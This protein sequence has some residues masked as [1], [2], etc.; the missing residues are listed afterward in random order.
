MTG[1]TAEVDR[2]LAGPARLPDEA[3]SVLLLAR[4]I[5]TGSADERARRTA[6]SIAGAGTPFE[7][8]YFLGR[9]ADLGRAS[10]VVAFL[11]GP[12]GASLEPYDR[13][14]LKL[15]AYSMLEW[16]VLE[17]KEI[18][19]ILDQGATAP[20]VTLVAAHLIRHPNAETAE[21]VFGQ[22]ERKPLPATAQN[23][24][25]HLA[26]LCMAG[27][28]GRDARMRQEAAVLGWG[29]SGNFPAWARISDFFESREP[30][31][32][33]AV[34]LPSLYQLPLEVVYAMAAGYHAAAAA[35]AHG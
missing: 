28:N 35:P 27:V 29:G 2:L 19:F 26:L 21:L 5:R 13:E 34:F 7:L 33:P 11:D 1:D 10:D 32:N 6:L 23:S 8:Y 3:R 9:L 30:A 18:G 15:D 25:A 16:R 17:R 31:R 12:G 22:L 20:V 24:G 14:S 4:D